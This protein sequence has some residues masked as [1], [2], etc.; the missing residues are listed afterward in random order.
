MSIQFYYTPQSSAGRVHASLQAL[1]VPYDEILVDLRAGDQKQPEFLAK[2]PNGKVPLLVI[3]GTP[4]F[5][6]VAIQIA[7]GERYGVEKGLWPALHSPEHLTAIT[8]LVWAQVNLTASAFRYMQHTSD[9]VPKE[10]HNPE[11]AAAALAEVRAEL[12]ILD[13]HLHGRDFITGPHRSLT[14]IDLSATLG[15]ALM[16]MKFDLAAYPNVAAWLT[17]AGHDLH[18]AR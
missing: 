17:R 7:L 14:D 16:M 5:E 10:Q 15:W 11:A 4:V 1:G 6:S 18:A 9:Y 3:D 12:K 2:N 13:G 8:W